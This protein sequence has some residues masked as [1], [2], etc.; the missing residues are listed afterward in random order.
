MFRPVLK[1]KLLLCL[2][3][4]FFSNAENEQEF[5]EVLSEDGQIEVYVR[6]TPSASV[7]KDVEE[8][9]EA[10]KKDPY[11]FCDTPMQDPMK[12]LVMRQLNEPCE[13]IS[14][15]DLKRIQGL[16]LD[17][18]HLESIG[19]EDF[20]GLD[21]LVHLELYNNG[22]QDIHPESFKNLTQLSH[23][24]IRQNLIKSMDPFLLSS[25]ADLTYLNLSHNLLTEL[26]KEFL[27]NALQLKYLN[28]SHNLLTKISVEVF[29]SLSQLQS[30][31]LSHNELTEAASE[32]FRIFKS[33]LDLDL[34]HNKLTEL[35][36]SSFEHLLR[37]NLSHNQLSSIMWFDA[38]DVSSFNK[39]MELDI[40]HNQLNS[41][42][43]DLVSRW[44]ALKIFNYS[45]NTLNTIEINPKRD[46]Y[47]TGVD[48]EW[49]DC[50]L[51]SCS[52][53][54]A[55]ISVNKE[56]YKFMRCRGHQPDSKCTRQAKQ[57]KKDLSEGHTLVLQM[58]DEF[59]KSVEKKSF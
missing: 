15:E 42:P 34:S 26:P 32:I 19:P 47:D 14:R 46:V 24:V 27:N 39:L 58:E 12:F 52:N 54:Y 5:Y 17:N 7:Q 40:S 30:L 56:R 28:L 41:I 49:Y 51:R 43:W 55:Y 11:S 18:V 3:M 29:S 37:L 22:L 25:L 10:S 53:S 20:T 45:R 21:N 36:L 16:T 8:V 9:S 35:Y 57:W 38:D 13:K 33:L 4:S 2:L 31:D 44:T 59:I 48:R 1:T 6:N 23:L 50:W